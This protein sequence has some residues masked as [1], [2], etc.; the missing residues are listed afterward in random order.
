MAHYIEVCKCGAVIRQCRCPGPHKTRVVRESCSACSGTRSK[1]IKHT[2]K[3]C[4]FCGEPGAILPSENNEG[5]FDLG[6]QDEECI[7]YRMVP[8]LFPDDLHGIVADWN[9]REGA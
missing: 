7:A 8:M 1:S 3:P 6:C 5:V 4:P 9:K 2:L